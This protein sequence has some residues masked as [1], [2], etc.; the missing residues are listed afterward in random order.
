MRDGGGVQVHGGLPLQL[1]RTLHGRISCCV[2]VSCSQKPCFR[3]HLSHSTR[4]I[5]AAATAVDVGLAPVLNA[6]V[7]GECSAADAGDTIVGQAVTVDD[8]G[9]PRA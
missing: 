6:V 9:L 1:F 7:A 2:H 5:A 3:P 8:A 4:C